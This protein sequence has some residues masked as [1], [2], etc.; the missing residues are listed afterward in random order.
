MA[1]GRRRF[2]SGFGEG[3]E[4]EAETGVVK[5]DWSRAP[6]ESR[7]LGTAGPLT[8]SHGVETRSSLTTTS[9]VLRTGRGRVGEETTAACLPG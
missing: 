4:A 6:K 8:I 2:R 5:D 7:R 9:R 3:E 1:M